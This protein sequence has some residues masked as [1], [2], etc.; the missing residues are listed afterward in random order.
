MFNDIT[1]KKKK[2]QVNIELCQQPVNA[3]YWKK[4]AVKALCG[5]HVCPAACHLV[6]ATKPFVG[7]SWNSENSFL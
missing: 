6:P 1:N 5:E 3:E 7:F 4:T 2:T